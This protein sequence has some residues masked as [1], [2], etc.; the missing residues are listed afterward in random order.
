[1]FEC[2]IN[3]VERKMVIPDRTVGINDLAKV[4]FKRKQ[5]LSKSKHMLDFFIFD[6]IR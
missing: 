6:N 3:I 5:D 4:C 2:L 1:M